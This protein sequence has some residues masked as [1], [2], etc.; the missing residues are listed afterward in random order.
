MDDT[1]PEVRQML[2]ER[3]RALAPDER[4]RLCLDMYDFARS[5][6]EASLPPGLDQRERHRQICE[7][8]Y[9]KDFADKVYPK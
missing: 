8:F 6:V 9:G 1:A 2:T 5:L 7:R 4:V 3:Y